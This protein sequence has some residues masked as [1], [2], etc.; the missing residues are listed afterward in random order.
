[1]HLILNSD[2]AHALAGVQAAKPD[3]RPCEALRAIGDAATEMLSEGLG[4]ATGESWLDE[5]VTRAA[6]RLT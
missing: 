2:L 3:A 1:M 5:L 6:T 4:R